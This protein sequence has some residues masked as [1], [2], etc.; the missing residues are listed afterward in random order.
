MTTKGNG[1][2]FVDNWSCGVSGLPESDLM[3]GGGRG[4]G[5]GPGEI[6]KLESI[7]AVI[8]QNGDDFPIITVG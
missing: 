3:M 4:R 5:G 2:E 1:R 6:C 7:M 8:C